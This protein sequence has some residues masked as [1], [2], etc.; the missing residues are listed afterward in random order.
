MRQTRIRISLATSALAM[1]FGGAN[2]ACAAQAGAAPPAATTGTTA[3]TAS[4]DAE[5]ARD[6]ITHVNKAVQVVQQMERDREL[7]AA[8]RRAKGVFVVPDYGRAAL[9]VGARG[10][11]GVLLVRRANTWSDPSFYN[12]GGISAGLQA[13]VEAGSVAFILNDQK[14]VDSFKQDN[15]FSLNAD[16]GLTVVNWSKKGQASAGRGDIIVWSDTEGLFGGAAVSVTDIN[17]DADETA[18]Y[19]GRRVAAREVLAGKVANPQAAALKQALAAAAD[20]N[21]AGSMGS[22]AAGSTSAGS[23][24]EKD[25]KHRR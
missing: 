5:S 10:G 18:S 23:G 15:K 17:Y 16:T 2:L 11:A 22:S 12:M 6:A 19:Y 13:G 8:L 1:A 21:Q 3:A 7:A 9:G 14:A 4:I 24:T 25:T 20:D